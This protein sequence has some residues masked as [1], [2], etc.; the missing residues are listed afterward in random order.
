MTIAFI[1]PRMLVG[2]AETYI[3]RKCNWLVSKGHHCLI[4]S[5]GGDFYKD[6]H[7]S[8]ERIVINSIDLPTWHLKKKE[9][10]TLITE[11]SKILINKQVDIIEAH[12]SYPAV[13]TAIAY[14]YTRI[15]YVVNVLS[16]LAFKK[17]P[18]LKIL[19]SRLSTIE[20]FYTVSKQSAKYFSESVYKEK[21]KSKVINIPI[22][23]PNILQIENI[24]KS[25][26][27]KYVLS[28]ARMANEKMYI[29]SLVEGF[30][31][32]ILKQKIPYDVKLKIVGDG[33][34]MDGVSDLVFKSNKLIGNES[35]QLLGYLYG[36]ELDALYQDCFIYAGMG[37]TLLIASSYKKASVVVGFEKET[38][39]FAWGFWGESKEDADYIV[40]YKNR[41]AKKSTF[42]EAITYAFDNPKRIN[43]IGELAFRLYSEHYALDTLMNEWLSVY[44]R[45]VDDESL[46]KKMDSIYVSLRRNSIILSKL[47]KVYSFF[48]NK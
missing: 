48:V 17:N 28:V 41:D 30:T 36:N 38:M 47:Y 43:E 2:G 1:T 39:Q 26:E 21:N 24:N 19:C 11:L 10:N 29:K 15:P 23:S 6:C 22:P 3:I 16:D 32:F 18:L 44:Y 8:V 14:K 12:N 7:S 9:F 5:S 46:T 27:G 20:L 37:T 13:Y 40:G 33:P 42:E 4:V 34:L 31:N 45:I 35:I 25:D